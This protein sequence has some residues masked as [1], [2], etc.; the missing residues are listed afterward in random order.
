MMRDTD[1]TYSST[2]SKPTDNPN[3]S[4]ATHA[5][6]TSTKVTLIKGTS[7]EATPSMTTPTGATST[8]STP[9]K[10][11]P[12]T[13]QPSLEKNI[14]RFVTQK[15]RGIVYVFIL[16]FFGCQLVISTLFSCAI[17]FQLVFCF[18]LCIRANE[19]IRQKAVE[20]TAKELNKAKEE[21]VDRKKL[22]RDQVSYD[23]YTVKFI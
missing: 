16:P 18:A 13:S 5:N 7:T 19:L 1:E 17:F 22:A 3:P 10:Y 21:E 15:E 20:K 11:T 4:E 14:E 8:E 12:C 9:T 23:P 2:S 6:Y